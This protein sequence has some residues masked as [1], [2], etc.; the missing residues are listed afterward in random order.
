MRKSHKNVVK[1]SDMGM[2]GGGR[3]ISLTQFSVH[4][5]Y[6]VSVLN[7]KMMVFSVEKDGN[8]KSKER[9]KI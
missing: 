2:G 3:I 9:N 6:R 1:K 7:M 4:F 8:T 5:F